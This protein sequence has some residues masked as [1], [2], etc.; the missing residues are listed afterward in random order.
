M[1]EF[2]NHHIDTSQLPSIDEVSFLALDPKYK[3]VVVIN[4]TL[5][6]LIII[7]AGLIFYWWDF[8][9]EKEDNPQMIAAVT[10]VAAVV[11]AL[12]VWVISILGFSK[13]SYA[14]REHDVIYRSGIILKREIVIPYNRVQHVALHEGMISRMYQLAALEFYTAGGASGDLKIPGI[15]KEQAERIKQFIVDKVHQVH[16][17]NKPEISDRAEENQPENKDI[18]TTD[19]EF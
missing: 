12:F 9:I 1:K 2:S 5:V 4:A 10:L 11:I 16:F 17:D 18:S 7:G 13:K 6:S 19:G 15:P 3:K 8:K 14:F